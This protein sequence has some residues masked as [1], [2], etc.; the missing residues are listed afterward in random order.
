MVLVLT[1]DTFAKEVL[2]SQLPVLV[3]FFAGWCP[4]CKLLAPIIEEL[5]QELQGKVKIAKLNID[6]AQNIAGRY[7]VMSVPTMIVFED[8]KEKKRIIGLRNKADLL[9]ELEV[10][11][12]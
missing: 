10:N 2:Q 6:E 11:S 4:P 3:D 12:Q 1:Q 7:Q 8:G 5:A 9:K